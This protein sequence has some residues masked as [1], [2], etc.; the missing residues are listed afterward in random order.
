MQAVRTVSRGTIVEL[1]HAFKH[2]E[3][4]SA[5]LVSSELVLLCC[6]ESLLLDDL[7]VLGLRDSLTYLFEV[8]TLEHHGFNLLN[9]KVEGLVDILL[10]LSSF[11][12]LLDLLI[13]LA[14]EL[15]VVFDAFPN[16]QVNVDF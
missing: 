16:Q 11:L 9:L 6:C 14:L 8:L 10:H 12:G 7:I 4:S 13:C 1:V 2:S 3:C 5:S 15:L